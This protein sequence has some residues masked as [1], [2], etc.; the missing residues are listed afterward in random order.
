MCR[1]NGS[2]SEGRIEQTLIFLSLK[3][4]CSNNSGNTIVP[5]LYNFLTQNYT[6]L[7]LRCSKNIFLGQF[8]GKKKENI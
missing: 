1:N 3:N 4:Y 8:I 5:T 2:E 7:G 6:D